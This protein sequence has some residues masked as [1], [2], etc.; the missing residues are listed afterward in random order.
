M[1]YAQTARRQRWA[2]CTVSEHTAAAAAAAFASII[3]WPSTY[4]TRSSSFRVQRKATPSFPPPSPSSK[5]T[6]PSGRQA[7]IINKTSPPSPFPFPPFP[8]PPTTND[9]L[10][11]PLLLVVGE[12]CECASVH[13]V[14]FVDVKMFLR[15]ECYKVCNFYIRYCARCANYLSFLSR[16]LFSLFLY[17]SSF[18]SSSP[19]VLI[20]RR[21]FLSPYLSL[22]LL[23]FPLPKKYQDLAA[24]R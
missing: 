2:H 4:Y 16:Y 11:F 14:V 18:R 1:H 15:I 13:V 21:G 20:F 10:A 8:L 24:P 9:Q 7:H 17:P 5:R 22:P 12:V 6:N 3:S 23:L 19:C